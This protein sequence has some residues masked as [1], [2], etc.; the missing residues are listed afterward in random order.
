MSRLRARPLAI[1]LAA[2]ATAGV[3]LAVLATANVDD[4]GEAGIT[5]E[6]QRV[7]P[8][9]AE[10][11]L[12][13][14]AEIVRPAAIY[15][16]SPQNGE[17]VRTFPGTVQPARASRLAFRVS[18]PVIEL[19]VR[20]GD[21]VETGALLAQIDPRDYRIAV[22]RLRANL[23]SA[24]ASSRLAQL[25]YERS[26]Q[27]L[28]RGNAPQAVVDRDEAERDQARAEI[29]SIRQQLAA[30]E[31]AL[32]DTSLVAPFTGRVAGLH[33]E[34]FDFVNAGQPAITL[35][36][37]SGAELVVF[38][39]ERLMPRLESV[40]RIEIELADFPGERFLAE[41]REI[42]SDQGA[43]AGAY[44]TTLRKTALSAPAPLAGLSG[45]GRFVFKKG[46]EDSAV[47]VPTSA[48]F[49]SQ[50]GG[51]YVWGVASGDPLRVS[52]KRVVVEGFAGDRAR[53][54]D[55]LRA[56]DRIVAYG[57][58]F[59]TEG[60]PVRPLGDAVALRGGRP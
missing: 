23:R 57:V 53:I 20:E 34:A 15:T 13:A 29:A 52:A 3:V 54:V 19:P 59:L 45:V 38:I 16:V 36:D 41:V 49:A 35:H 10:S 50:D 6:G 7:S 5:V 12:G 51:S 33:I 17:E 28:Q 18:G 9:D 2:A 1:G 30:A 14:H 27:L 22:E 4:G 47:T 56:G 24:E 37:T 44:R 58:D 40:S 42:A 31:A 60:Q 46:Q 55:G 39:P 26:T 8:P 48:V 43:D 25:N 21:L 32:A 11:Q